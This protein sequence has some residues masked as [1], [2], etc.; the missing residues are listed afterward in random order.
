[1][2][3]SS[4]SPEI[5]TG[6]G[7]ATGQ[8][9]SGPANE[10]FRESLARLLGHA[11]LETVPTGILHI[12]PWTLRTVLS[13]TGAEDPICAG[14]R[15]WEQHY[16]DLQSSVLAGSD[17]GERLGPLATLKARARELA[18]EGIT[19][20]AVFDIHYHRPD[21]RLV[22]EVLH[23]AR[24]RRAIAIPENPAE[25]VEAS[26]AVMAS[27]LLPD[28]FEYFSL[29]PP[30]HEG[31]TVRFRLDPDFVL[32]SSS[33]RPS[34]IEADF[35]DGRGGREL[36]LGEE[37][38]VDYAG[39]S[40]P[41]SIRIRLHYPTETRE[42][43][44]VLE[45]SPSLSIPQPDTSWAIQATIPYEGQA[46][47]GIAYVLYGSDNGVKH[48]SVVRPVILS[49]GFPGGYSWSYLYA[50]LNGQDMVSILLQAGYD[51]VVLTYTDGSDYVQRNAFVAVA[52]IQQAIASRSG[53]Q[54]L[55]V[56]GASMGG[57][58]TR[59]A[60]WYM[61]QNNLDHQ[62]GIFL[63]FD[64]PQQGG[65]VPPSDQWFIQGLAET[66]NS[67]AKA[68]AALLASFAAR[69]LLY[70]CVPEW[71]GDGTIP[72]TDPLHTQLYSSFGYPTK[73]RTIGVADGCGNGQQIIP[74]QAHVMDWSGNV[75]A[76]GDTWALATTTGTIKIAD[77]YAA[78]LDFWSEYSFSVTNV[79]NYDGAPG[80]LTN[81]N[82]TLADAIIASGYG[83][84]THAYD[85]NCFIPTV[86]SLD[87]VN[88]GGN[89]YVPVPVQ[90]A[91]TAFDAYFVSSANQGHVAL[92]GEIA[93]FLLTELLGA[94]SFP[95]KAPLAAVSI[96]AGWQDVFAVGQDGGVYNTWIHGGPQWGG[97]LRIGT[98]TL[99][100]GTQIAA[101]SD[102]PGWL[103]L[104]AVGNDGN[105]YSTWNHGALEWGPWSQLPLKTFPPGAPIAGVSANP[106]WL[107]V[108][109]VGSDGGV[110]T[111]FWHN[112][113]AWSAWT[114]I[115]QGVFSVGTPLTA[116]SDGA[117]NIDLFG[118]GTDGCVYGAYW[119][120]GPWQAWGP[121]G[122]QTFAQRTPV[123]AVSD[124]PGWLD[125][126]A[127]GTDGLV[128]S[129][130]NHGGGWPA[131]PWGAIDNTTFPPGAP[132]AAVSANPRW[133]DVFVVDAGGGVS[134]SFW[135]NG[136]AW[137]AWTRIGA[138]AF[139]VGTP[140]AAISTGPGSIN[141]FGVG[142]NSAVWTAYE[143]GGN[144]SWIAWIALPWPH[145]TA[146]LPE[147]MA[148][149][150]D[151]SDA[152]GHHRPSGPGQLAPALPSA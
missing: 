125:L 63:S 137:S 123:A 82:G 19:P 85:L 20:I 11:T 131:G 150:A 44:F 138:G 91:S 73:P 106:G 23:A 107:D 58:I 52:C 115:G 144:G 40:S 50:M 143:Q 45:V 61:E 141:V 152:P 86:S 5:S 92:T 129:T 88:P 21:G 47:S 142:T 48:T 74:D 6:S 147:L 111:S 149:G 68:S 113:P 51:L 119:A 81:A 122:T 139:A 71:I 89:P 75:C 83:S 98:Q 134:T 94:P 4:Q 26:R 41:A 140:C 2:S 13:F 124:Q 103:D 151:A 54:P 14:Q 87:L 10:E 84:V 127:V 66:G 145:A 93:G 69:Q 46:N 120:G 102:N 34:S 136:P 67:T 128:H 49:E 28:R 132:I 65:H 27:A 15:S 33:T 38:L 109:V 64:S 31:T 105:V 59:Y 77:L 39:I 90:G 118:V 72:L 56:G 126:F 80:G 18:A 130:W 55:V 114:R 24:S 9:S 110:Y 32:T 101:V 78:S 79:V 104:F 53:T 121:I 25:R 148:A 16:Q 62:C 17:A 42:G 95:Q 22:E 96:E 135:H 116:V 146:A 7:V 100:P 29:L 8:G 1:M 30:V 99:A 117:G 133:L 3:A 60:L 97:W 76:Y 43:G 37:V 35:G 112:G 12:K 36:R 70:Y 108:F 57:L